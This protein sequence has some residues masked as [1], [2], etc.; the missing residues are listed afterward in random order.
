MKDPNECSLEQIS[1]CHGD[2]RKH[3]RAPGK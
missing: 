2:A 1:K 3:P